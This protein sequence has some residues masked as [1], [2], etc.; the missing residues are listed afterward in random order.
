M[1]L[2]HVIYWLPSIGCNVANKP[3]H[4]KKKVSN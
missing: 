2:E 4:L 1:G 3:H